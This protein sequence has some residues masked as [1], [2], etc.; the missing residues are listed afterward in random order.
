M[1][2]KN[3]SEDEQHAQLKQCM[4]QQW[5]SLIDLTLLQV[6]PL[7]LPPTHSS[8]AAASPRRLQAGV[9]D[10]S[11]AWKQAGRMHLTLGSRLR[12]AG[13][14]RRLLSVLLCSTSFGTFPVLQHE[15][16]F[17]NDYAK[18]VF[19]LGFFFRFYESKLVIP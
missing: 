2:G 6:V 8:A 15:A 18:A 13:A 9:H 11:D 4:L 7:V 14:A 16:R 19:Y 5:Q 3:R 1:T 17:K 10:A 12:S